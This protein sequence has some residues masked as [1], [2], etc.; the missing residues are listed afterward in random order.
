M[1]N[2]WKSLGLWYGIGFI[3]S[4]GIIFGLGK[5]FN[6]QTQKTTTTFTTNGITQFRKGMDIA[7]GVKL[8]YKVDFSKYDQI[9]TLPAERDLAKRQ[10]I[11]VILKNIDNRISALGVSDYSARQQNI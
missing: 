10:A 7:G 3:I 8:T 1:K 2:K 4:L 11:G 5:S 6:E 9:Y